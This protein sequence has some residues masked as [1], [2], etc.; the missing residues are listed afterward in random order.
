MSIQHRPDRASPWR[1]RFRVGDGREVSRSFRR[2]VDA[3]AWLED[4]RAAIRRGDWVDP[5]RGAVL[6]EV[7]TAE[8]LAGKRHL[9]ARTVET[10]EA[11]ARRVEPYLAGL[12]LGRIRLERLELMV[13]GLSARYAPETVAKS[14]RLVRMV[15]ARA[16]A[17]RRLVRS[18]AEGLAAPPVPKRDMRIL[19]AGQVEELADA[20]PARYRSIPVVAA[21]TGLRFGE[22]AGLQVDSFDMLRRRLEVRT[23]LKEPTGAEPFLGPPKSKA[24][25]RTI[26]IPKLV[27]SELDRHIGM[28]PPVDGLVWTTESG[29]V[30]RRGSFSRIW[31]AAVKRS[32]G[33]P[34]RLHDLRHT[35]AAWLIALGEHPK[36]IQQR[37][38]HGSISVTLDRYGHLMEG[39]DE[40]AAE[41]LDSLRRGPNAAQETDVRP[42]GTSENPQ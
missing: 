18:P 5:E 42:D 27:V 34:C 1:A 36:T 40:G 26:A 7:Y 6:W 25:A 9:A 37:L 41:K 28:F 10:Y 16:V 21:Y 3:L 19:S 29:E 11:A 31:R 2:K 23:V 32:V 33:A 8:V 24:S 35:H 14:V 22:L 4:Q 13:S 17:H 30:L 15:F 39:L 12:P 20:M 38:G